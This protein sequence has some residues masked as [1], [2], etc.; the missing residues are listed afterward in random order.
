MEEVM[1]D[2]YAGGYD[3]RLGDISTDSQPSQLLE[4]KSHIARSQNQYR[5]FHLLG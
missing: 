3:M 4:R 1:R 5:I 2:A